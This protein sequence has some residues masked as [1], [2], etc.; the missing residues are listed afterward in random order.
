[1]KGSKLLKVSSILMIISG[2]LGL[3]ASVLMIATGTVLFGLLGI[4]GIGALLTTIV[5]IDTTVWSILELVAGIFGAKNWKNP[6]QTKKCI[7]LA[8]V[9]LAL[10]ILVNALTLGTGDG[11]LFTLLSVV[12]SLIIPTLYLIGA[13]QL[14]KNS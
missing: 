4:A 12:L 5:I 8:L 13:V 7:A 3:F 9:I 14:N 11:F 6:D 10:C 2:A 1:M